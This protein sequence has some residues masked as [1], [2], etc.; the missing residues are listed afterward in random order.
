MKDKNVY[1]ICLSIFPFMV[2]SGII[3]SILSL[4]FQSLGAGKSQIGLLYTCGATSGAVTAPFLG[5]LSDKIGRKKVLLLSMAIFAL[6]FLGY[7]LSRNY[8]HIFPIQ[9]GEGM[10]W[11]AL[12]TSAV[13]LIADF[14]PEERRGK[15]MGM[16]NTTWNLGWI[17]GPALGGFLSDQIG[18]RLTFLIC[19]FIITTGL[20]IGAFLL[21]KR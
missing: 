21:P 7:A 2:C 4:Y 19:A 11:A 1:L 16:Y 9:V 6:V 5:Q 20:A 18:F 3:Y 10:A 13:A 15:A 17:I 14:V 8:R 12:G